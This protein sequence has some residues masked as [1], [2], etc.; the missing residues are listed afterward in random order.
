MSSDMHPLC[1]SIPQHPSLSHDETDDDERALGTEG[2]RDGLYL[3]N[4]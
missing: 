4:T 3:L 2:G 1:P